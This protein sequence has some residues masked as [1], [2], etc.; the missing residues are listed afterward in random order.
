MQNQDIQAVEQRERGY[1]LLAR[2]FAKGI[3][4]EVYDQLLEVPVLASVLPDPYDPDQEGAVYHEMFGLNVLP[5]AGVF[6][7]QDGKLG[8]AIHQDLNH[9]YA[10]FGF[11]PVVLQGVPDHIATQLEFLAFLSGVERTQ[12]EST[13]L[14]ASMMT[15]ARQYQCEFLL[16]HTMRWCFPFF[17]SI[18]AQQNPFFSE[19]ASLT[20]ALIVQHSME[21]K[22]VDQ[23]GPLL[24]ASADI[25]SDSKTGVKE[26]ASFL[27]RPIWSGI[28]LTRKDIKALASS[29][30]VPSGFGDRVQTLSTIFRSAINFDVLP[31]LLGKLKEQ[32]RFHIGEYNEQIAAIDEGLSP[33]LMQWQFKAE[34]TL[35]L[36]DNIEVE[37]QRLT[38]LD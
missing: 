11:T 36:L 32:V 12:V 28:Y 15:A 37:L 26:I 13:P 2:I 8:G 38:D 17:S 23:K 34:Q 1:T 14:D 35:V 24:P 29:L 21:V 22:S 9:W 16:E 33:S 5:Y 30:K 27:C 10:S 4:P 25:L 7:T 31:G 20:Q 3:T 18:Q 19:V 6:L